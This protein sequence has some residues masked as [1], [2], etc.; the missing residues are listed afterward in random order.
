MEQNFWTAF[1]ASLMAGAVTT[2]GIFAIRRFEGWARQNVTYFACF[3]AGVLIAV[4]FLHIIPTSF[5]MSPL[6]PVYLISGLAFTPFSTASCTRSASA[7]A[8]L[9]ARSWR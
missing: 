3:A 8:C 4:S 6:A 9:R 5:A 7:S 2:S 1:A